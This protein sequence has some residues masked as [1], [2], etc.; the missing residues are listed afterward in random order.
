MG[1]L[2][3]AAEGQNVNTICNLLI[4]SF[5]RIVYSRYVGISLNI[6]NIIETDVERKL[7][8]SVEQ[9]V[10]T[11]EKYLIGQFQGH[12]YVDNLDQASLEKQREDSD[13]LT[14]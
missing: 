8:I 14:I 1:E 10:W 4:N 11:L 3:Y 5:Q 6:I 7:R 9:G 12:E 13:K 2:V